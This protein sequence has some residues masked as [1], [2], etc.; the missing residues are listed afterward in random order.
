M[1][2]RRSIMSRKLAAL[3][4]RAGKAPNRRGTILVVILGALAL[5]SVI[6]VAYVSVGKGDRRTAMV[7]RRDANVNEVIDRVVDYI[8]TDIIAADVFS[9]YKQAP[10][11]TP[12]GG[13]MRE[14]WD[15]PY[16]G[17]LAK[18][19]DDTLGAGHP[20]EYR[21]SPVGT[22][23]ADLYPNDD[24]DV[25]DLRPFPGSDPWLA[26]TMPTW[27]N[28]DIDIPSDPAFLDIM[29][30]G[31]ISN[32]APDGRFANLFALRNNF[33]VRS[34]G[35]S[36]ERRLGHGLTLF[37]PN[38]SRPYNTDPDIDVY[39]GTQSI[40]AYSQNTGAEDAQ[41]DTPAH[42]DT[43]QRHMFRPA[44]DAVHG[45]DS[46]LY[47]HYQYADTD[48][49][50]YFDARWQELVDSS[51]PDSPSSILPQNGQFRWVVASRIIDLSSM[52]NVNTAT[53][54]TAGT[55]RPDEKYPIGHT[56]ADVDLVRLLADVDNF[57]EYGETYHS[58]YFLAERFDE[59][60]LQV[61]RLY[62]DE[63]D[64]TEVS[65]SARR[66][67][68]Y[69]YRTISD[70]GIPE[71]NETVPD[72]TPTPRQ[73]L[74]Q[75]NSRSA[76]LNDVGLSRQPVL[77]TVAWGIGGLF[78]VDDQI[79]LMTRHGANDDSRVSRLEQ[80]IGGRHPNQDPDPTMGFRWYSPLRENWPTTLEIGFHDSFRQGAYDV[81]GD[82]IIDGNAQLKLTWDKRRLL[83][84]VS[85][86]R[87]L[88]SG[89][90]AYPDVNEN[91]GF[92]Y[93]TYLSASMVR[94]DFGSDDT[95]LDAFAA[96]RA[97]SGIDGTRPNPD[98]LFEAYAFALLP[99]MD[100]IANQSL[101]DFEA[102]K[103]PGSSRYATTTYG[104]DPLFAYLTAAHM[105][106]NAIDMFDDDNEI[107]GMNDDL[108]LNLGANTQHSSTR[109]PSA[110]T[111]VLAN[112]F[113]N[114]TIGYQFEQLEVDRDLL[115]DKA[116][117]EDFPQGAVNVYGV[118]PQ[119]FLTEVA[120]VLVFTDQDV[121]PDGDGNPLFAGNDEWMNFDPTI[122]G[123]PPPR[124]TINTKIPPKFTNRQIL[125][126]PNRLTGDTCS[127]DQ[128]DFVFQLLV[129][130]LTNPF[131]VDIELSDGDDYY[132]IQ[133]GGNYF[134]LEHKPDG[135]LDDG[136]NDQDRDV[137]RPG[138]TRNYV[139]LSHS[140]QDVENYIET[141]VDD[142][143][144]A[145]LDD[146]LEDNFDLLRDDG[147]RSIHGIIEAVNP[148]SGSST[149]VERFFPADP[150]D[151][152]LDDVAEED[153]AEVRL[154]RTKRR[155][156]NPSERRTDLLADRLRHPMMKE[157][158]NREGTGESNIT[159]SEAG[160]D[161]TQGGTPSTWEDNSG[162]T[163]VLWGSVKRP[164]SPPT[165]PND[166]SIGVPQGAIP[167]WCLERR[168]GVGDTLNQDT[169]NS[170]SF[171]VSSFEYEEFTDFIMD[172]TFADS[173]DVDTLI[174]TISR[175]PSNKPGLENIA[176]VMSTDIDELDTENDL[177]LPYR[178]IYPQI[179]TNNRVWLGDPDASLDP[180]GDD[181]T[182]SLTG[183][184]FKRLR[185]GDM[186]LPLAIGPTHDPSG[187]THDG[188]GWV[189]L[190][191]KL[192]SAL[193]YDGNAGLGGGTEERISPFAEL[194]RR[195]DRGNIILDSY[196]PFEDDNGNGVFE[197]IDGNTGDIVRGSGNP[198]AVDILD[199]FVAVDS[200]FD[201]IVKP[202][203]GKIN[204]NTAPLEVL[205]TL[206]QLSPPE[207]SDARTGQ[208][209]WWWDPVNANLH[210]ER[211]D[212]AST[213]V[214]Y[215]DKRA[216]WPRGIDPTQDN[217]LNFD[218]LASDSGGAD[219]FDPDPNR[220][221]PTNAF[222]RQARTAI[223][224]LRE[225][226]GFAS[227]GE[228]LNVRDTLFGGGIGGGGGQ[229]AAP[230]DMDRLG[231]AD[232]GLIVNP[233]NIEERGLES[234]F[235]IRQDDNVRDDTDEIDSEF[236]Q[237][238]M[239]ANGL[240]NTI[241][242]RSDV[243]AVWFVIHGYQRSDVEGLRDDEPM[244]PS[245]ARRYLMIVDRSNVTDLG[246]KPKILA[247]KQLPL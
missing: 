216:M 128:G 183:D 194:Y 70:N 161:K 122:P 86:G 148:S 167:A 55:S 166:P 25:I 118:E 49:D 64:R 116:D 156:A 151:G 75:Y 93:P 139:V 243:Y 178:R 202:T 145:H 3:R 228:I 209:Y 141:W 163:M 181:D 210:D 20:D 31:K 171:S 203:Y 130:Q 21:F 239:L 101:D 124:V 88:Q 7:V 135:G 176:G 208:S 215:R 82:G 199:A 91:N 8:A 123:E 6:T 185:L 189:T 96:L 244:V 44:R 52:V 24:N 77:N 131:G 196:V 152:C 170:Q 125:L 119:P 192:C 100:E 245:V 111:L 112:D 138:E 29:D 79:E 129:F 40:I 230:H 90:I 214:A 109:G 164:D 197:Y 85:G 175:I 67:F 102:W 47:L 89:P 190:S 114:N 234:A 211:S 173:P 220:V 36:G 13:Y 142:E 59:P 205:R 246:D 157:T 191:E 127:T 153:L 5:L 54:I 180:I 48:G 99:H 133:Y 115:P 126:P 1:L 146:W 12:D 222:S 92:A 238:L 84:V 69:I 108:G 35:M 224:G 134:K 32:I 198:V 247:I 66:E 120:S 83:T 65:T 195:T 242:V 168:V 50:G 241:D 147:T 227:V 184:E 132:Y 240:F 103:T 14:A 213:I 81:D 43:D 155:Q 231:V 137:L 106:A 140:K 22:F 236:D 218:E 34:G 110:F 232:D 121:D 169:R 2:R 174:N 42:W 117:L 76:Y 27:L 19:D 9:V 72:V 63:L 159:S 136:T 223:S 207:G 56:P 78:I 80:A 235:Y 95:P 62:L 150:D 28:Y 206:P 39:P 4:A 201:S 143:A 172:S 38:G 26:D 193:G 154:W 144:D 74:T 187:A 113:Q 226:P 61:P 15:Y 177:Q 233:I 221:D 73:R 105:T 11:G 10:A 71:P 41:L 98:P 182:P 97:A 217:A 179:N 37:R 68:S 46:P 212:I 53:S 57:A 30:W 188:D 33:D 158:L 186:L 162:L 200:Q 219:A 229:Y 104:D 94:L 160:P 45:P 51:N 18:S 16:T 237:K 23:P 60:Y 107:Q 225:T 204:I 165:D 149:D 17:W 87:S 58:E